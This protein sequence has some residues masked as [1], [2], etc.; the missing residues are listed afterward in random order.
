MFIGLEIFMLITGII[1]LAR[2][3]LRLGKDSVIEDAPGAA[4]SL[5]L[6]TPMPL[7]L[8][9]A[10]TVP[11]GIWMF[12]QAVTLAVLGIVFPVGYMVAGNQRRAAI[13]WDD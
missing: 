6:M 13:S 9:V 12:E 10:M 2:G 11:G 1:G 7:A 8:L 3:E 5:L 4:L